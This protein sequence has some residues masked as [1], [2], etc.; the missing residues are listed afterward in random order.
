MGAERH[1]EVSAPGTASDTAHG[2]LS[3]DHFHTPRDVQLNAV[4][5]SAPD[6]ASGLIPLV[7]LE[8]NETARPAHA[9]EAQQH[10]VPAST[11]YAPAANDS[12]DEVQAKRLAASISQHIDD[13][14]CLEYLRE[15]VTEQMP[16]LPRAQFNAKMLQ[17]K[18]VNDQVAGG[19]PI[20]E[21]NLL[22]VQLAK[23]N[24]QIPALMAGVK[25][26]YP[27][28]KLDW[29]FYGTDDEFATKTIEEQGKTFTANGGNHGGRIST[30]P[31][32]DTARE[33]ADRKVIASRE[34]SPAV[35]G[36]A[37]PDSTVKMLKANG[38]LKEDEIPDR[39]DQT[40]GKFQPAAIQTL[41]DKGFFFPI[42]GKSA[43]QYWLKKFPGLANAPEAPNTGADAV[44][45][46]DIAKEVAQRVP[47][48]AD[49]AQIASALDAVR[50][51][52]EAAGDGQGART[53]GD[54][55]AKL[56]DNSDPGNAEFVS[57]LKDQVSAVKG[58]A[59]DISVEPQLAAARA[60]LPEIKYTQTTI[61]ANG[62][63]I[64]ENAVVGRAPAVSPEERTALDE[65]SQRRTAIERELQDPNLSDARRAELVK[66]QDGMK[67]FDTNPEFRH[68]AI[69]LAERNGFELKPGEGGAGG[70]LLGVG[71]LFVAIG[72][73]V[74]C[75]SRE[76]SYDHHAS[77]N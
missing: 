57:K 27:N 44:L 68:K 39:P 34:G 30:T 40:E 75:N 71:F 41:R 52:H 43:E 20:E 23:S 36:F 50:A 16:N 59:L 76:S 56:S 12:A 22:A 17:L 26:R 37:L 11:A 15:F 53:I 77:V 31:R 64:N 24:I 3:D 54:V 9:H 51:K 21:P 67:Q 74:G 69:E 46:P 66:L 65:V 1:A 47:A 19:N 10:D 55:I 62:A 32:I 2:K 29:F 8:D 49:R 60:P 35:I 25:E 4:S 42:E 70:K 33:F 7:V 72:S 5:A 6:T 48:D 18:W 63:S 58:N 14:D 28:E 13:P 61:D 45:P 73:L 38:M